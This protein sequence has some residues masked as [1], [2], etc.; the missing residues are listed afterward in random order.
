MLKDDNLRTHLGDD[1][2]RIRPREMVDVH[3]VPVAQDVNDQYVGTVFGVVGGESLKVSAAGRYATRRPPWTKMQSMRLRPRARA[4]SRCRVDVADAI[5][6][7]ARLE[8]LDPLDETPRV[9]QHDR[10]ISKASAGA[11]RAPRRPETAGRHRLDQGV[12]V[13]RMVEVLM[14]EDDCIELARIAGRNV[15]SARTSAPGPGSTWICVA[16]NRIH[17]PPDARN[18]RAT[19]KRAPPLP[20]KRIEELKLTKHG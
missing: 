17:I 5:R 7:A 12:D 10:L 8:M 16:P 1:A 2:A 15:D 4:A 11:S 6:T 18:W 20:R 13:A 3:L 9:R 14:R 19:T